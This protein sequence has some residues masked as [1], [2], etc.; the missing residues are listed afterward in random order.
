M[1]HAVT[2]GQ[3]TVK[4][5]HIGYFFASTNQEKFFFNSRALF[6]VQAKLV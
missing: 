6:Y 1:K 5:G 4:L 2:D 3:G